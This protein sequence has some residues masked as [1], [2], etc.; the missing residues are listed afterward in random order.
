MDR[1]LLRIAVTSPALAQWADSYASIAARKSLLRKKLILLMAIL[2]SSSPEH[3]Y[4]ELIRDTRASAV[5]ARMALRG[6]LHG[7]RFI[8]GLLILG[9]IHFVCAVGGGAGERP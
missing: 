8:L 6:I 7:M 5:I 2:E 4:D 1:I 3:G 9:P